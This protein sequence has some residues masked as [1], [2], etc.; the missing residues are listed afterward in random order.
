MTVH[1]ESKK[2][3]AYTPKSYPSIDGGEQRF[4]TGELTKLQNSIAQ[5]IAVVS[6]LETRMNTNGLS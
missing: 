4:I 5:L 1:T 2:L 6:S 3:L